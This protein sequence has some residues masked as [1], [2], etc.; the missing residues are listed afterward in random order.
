MSHLRRR[1]LGVTTLLATAA[2]LMATTALAADRLLGSTFLA[3]AENDKDVIH[4]SCRPRVAA[5]KLKAQR[6]Q[7][8]IEALWVRYKNG[9]RDRLAVRDRIAEGGESRWIDLPGGHRCVGAIGIIGDTEL[10]R[11]Q[12]RVDVYGRY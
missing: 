7:V 9:D 5:I 10:S 12:A 8:E 4:T 2:A 11:D 1:T 3:R 6:G